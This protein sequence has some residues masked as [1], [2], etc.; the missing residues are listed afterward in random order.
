M[1]RL[2]KQWFTEHND[3]DQL[4]ERIIQFGEGNLLRGFI[5]WMVHQMNKQGLFIIKTDAK[6]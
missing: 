1:K 4:P 5:D 6:T 2:S 3:M